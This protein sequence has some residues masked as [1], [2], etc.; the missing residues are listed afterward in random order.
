MWCC[1]WHGGGEQI[2][3]D[4]LISERVKAYNLSGI[5]QNPSH[6]EQDSSSSVT[7]LCRFSPID[8]TI[9]LP[10]LKD[11][12]FNCKRVLQWKWTKLPLSEEAWPYFEPLGEDQVIQPEVFFHMLP[13][14][15]MTINW[16][17]RYGFSFHHCLL[18]SCYWQT[19]ALGPACSHGVIILIVFHEI[20]THPKISYII[21][22]C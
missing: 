10:V 15:K 16:L 20:M 6:L 3:A 2:T 9:D 13:L 14:N 12:Y 22:A 1:V 18:Y 8:L 7:F 19:T 21:P 17:W 4:I 5:N 11:N